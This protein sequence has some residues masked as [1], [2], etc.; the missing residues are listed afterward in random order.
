MQRLPKWRLL[1]AQVGYLW[2]RGR[3][4]LARRDQSA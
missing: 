2:A 4:A 3:V 1:A